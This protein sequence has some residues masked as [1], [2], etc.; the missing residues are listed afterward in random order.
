MSLLDEQSQLE[1]FK[2]FFGKRYRSHQEQTP[3]K[4]NKQKSMYQHRT[5]NACIFE[6]SVSKPIKEFIETEQSYVNQLEEIVY[7]IMKPIRESIVD[8]NKTAILDQYSFNRIFINMEDILNVNKSFL[9]SLKEYQQG[10]ITE[11]FGHILLK[12]F[13][14]FDCYKIF[15]LGK[16]N[17]LDCHT[18]NI[19][20]NKIYSKFLLNKEFKGNLGISDVLIS[21]IQRMTRYTLLIQV[22]LNAMSPNDVDIENLQEANTKISNINDMNYGDS[23]LLNL[24]HLIRDA[25]ASLIQTRQLLGYFDVTEL[26]LLSGKPSRPVTILVFTDKLMVVKRKNY[27]IQGKD[28]LENIEEQIKNTATSTMLQK[29]KEAYHGLPFEFKGWVDI[30]A[31]EIFDGLDDRPITFF[32]RSCLPK[33]S[34]NATEKECENYFRRSDRLYSILPNDNRSNGLNAYLEKKQELI[35]LCQKQF[36]VSKLK[37]TTNELYYESKFKRPT[38]THIYDEQTY[39]QAEYKNHILIIYTEDNHP[40]QH[41]DLN[42]LINND[43]WIVILITRHKSGGYKPIIRSRTNLIPIREMSREIEYEFMVNNDDQHKHDKNAPLNFIDTL[44]NNIFFYERRLRATEAFS[45]IH[46]GLLRTRGRSRSRSKSLT[47]AASH[48]SIGKLFARSRSSSPSKQHTLSKEQ[49]DIIDQAVATH[50]SDPIFKVAS[51]HKYTENPFQPTHDPSYT[52][53]P[54][55]DSSH[56]LRNSK[57]SKID[58][59]SHHWQNTKMNRFAT[60]DVFT[61]KNND[62]NFIDCFS[63]TVPQQRQQESL[64]YSGTNGDQD[65]SYHRPYPYTRRHFLHNPDSQSPETLFRPSSDSSSASSSNDSIPLDS[66]PYYLSRNSISGDSSSYHP[67]SSVSSYNSSLRSYFDDQNSDYSFDPRDRHGSI[68]STNS[69]L[70]EE[71]LMSI[72]DGSRRSSSRRASLHPSFYTQPQA[73]VNSTTQRPRSFNPN[74]NSIAMNIELL[75]TDFDHLIDHL[76]RSQ[77]QQLNAQ[78]RKH[79]YDTACESICDLRSHINSKID[80]FMNNTSHHSQ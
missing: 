13:S 27:N 39:H 17:S 68:K 37:D 62:I 26:S 73:P 45:C 57:P 59:K 44:W 2:T 70:Y 66:A 65:N 67:Y 11:S 72:I 71:K 18:Q 47:R 56:I 4:E 52:S 30:R 64:L 6:S 60:S 58:T 14:K 76:I 40:V 51:V 35:T 15:F 50:V 69:S 23:S 32:L 31:V 77:Q 38:Y 22:I 25:P 79:Y 33:Q 42:T 10:S 7:K 75:K 8:P 34:S 5:Q 55:H 53:N 9:S 63:E 12:H 21:P 43:V 29:A 49:P 28:Y 20:Q 1:Y 19:K 74:E 36:A 78:D 46:D 48:I 3:Q 41:I 16:S 54:I 24:Y 61:Q 80:A